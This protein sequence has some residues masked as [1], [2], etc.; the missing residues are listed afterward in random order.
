MW[1]QYILYLLTGSIAGEIVAHTAEHLWSNLREPP[2][3]LAMPDV[4][5]ATSPALT[6]RYHVRAEHIV[7][8]VAQMLGRTIDPA[9]MVS[10][11]KQPHDV[12]GDWFTGPF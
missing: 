1:N 8:T 2:R 5:E 4:P 9:P 10:G 6:T 12:P 7:A 11:R 3:R